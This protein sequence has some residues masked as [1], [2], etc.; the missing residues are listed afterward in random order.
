MTLVIAAKG[1]DFVVMG[2]DSKG[3]FQDSSG[4][5]VE[6]NIQQKLIKINDRTGILLFG[7][8]P[9]HAYYLIE[10]FKQGC[11]NEKKNVSD[12]AEDLAS[13]CRNEAR[14]F[15]DIPRYSPPDFG[16]IIAG[17]DKSAGKITPKCYS[18]TSGGGFSLGLY[19]HGFGIEG[20]PIIATYLFAK[21]FVKEMDLDDLVKLIVGSLHDTMNIDGDV[22]G[23]INITIIEDSGTRSIRRMDIDE[24]IKQWEMQTAY[25]TTSQFNEE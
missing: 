6:L 1:K 14:K 23:G 19:N 16:L 25:R 12:T 20:K 24:K 15:S 11:K 9:Y 22:G 7:N 21:N 10:K 13:F 3:T 2:A 5:R 17:I 8:K 18:L 4:T